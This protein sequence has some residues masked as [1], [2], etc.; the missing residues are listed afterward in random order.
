MTV[1]NAREEAA[2]REAKKA[3][4]VPDEDG[5]VTV[6]R[7]GRTGPARMEGAEL[8][9]KEMEEKEERKRKEME[10]AGFYRWQGRERRKREEG[11]LKRR[12][13]EDR[14]RMVGIRE[15]RRQVKPE[16]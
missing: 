3:R 12:F 7:G 2:A 10:K 8:K 5:F 9:G 14:R 1:F 11:E 15:G 6:S 13:E 4:N 16:K